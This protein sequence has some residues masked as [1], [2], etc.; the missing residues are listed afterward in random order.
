MSDSREPD[1]VGRS[2]VQAL[3]LKDKLTGST[4]PWKIVYMHQPPYASAGDGSID[5]AQWPYK[6]WGASVVLSGHS[7]VYERIMVDGFTYFVNGLGGGPIYSFDTPVFG[8]QVRFNEDYGAMIVEATIQRIVFKFVTR[9]AILI[10][11]YT[12]EK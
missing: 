8:S 10:D 4:A 6:E 1:G 2:S 7:H 5:W 11:S 3:W 12:I 9:S